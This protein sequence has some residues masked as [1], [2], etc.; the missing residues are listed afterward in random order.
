M[1][2]EERRARLVTRHRLGPNRAERPIGVARSLV[3]LHS[4]DP[5]S[6]YLSVWARTTEF[7]PPDLEHALYEERSLVRVL[8][9]R[10]TLFVVPRELVPVVYAA[11]T[12][13]IAASQRRRLEKFVA[14]SEV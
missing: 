2:A 5:V 4:T 12:R 1:T 10:R 11:C 7:A 13:T 3:A 8:G 14:E 6:V 9:M